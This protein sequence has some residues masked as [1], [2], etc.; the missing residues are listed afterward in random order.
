MDSIQ[1]GMCVC[2]SACESFPTD[3]KCQTPKDWK[4]SDFISTYSFPFGVLLGFGASCS[5]SAEIRA[6]NAVKLQSV[7]FIVKAFCAPTTAKRQ[8]T[9]KTEQNNQWEGKNST[10]RWQIVMGNGTKKRRRNGPF[11]LLVS[12]FVC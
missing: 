4:K 1:N 3:R 7:L 12:H 9:R 2:A 8:R 10:I 6:R 11:F 5:V